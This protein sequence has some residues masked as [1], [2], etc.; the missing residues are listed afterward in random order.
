[1]RHVADR[2]ADREITL[3]WTTA[4]VDYLAEGGYDPYFGARPLKR[5]I[6]ND[7]LNLLSQAIL[8]GEIPPKSHIELTAKNKKVTFKK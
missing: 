3:N 2:L 6:Q 5:L 1:M 8:K 7:T 4:L